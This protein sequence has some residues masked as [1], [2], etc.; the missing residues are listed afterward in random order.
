MNT[1]CMNP[2]YDNEIQQFLEFALERTRLDE[3]EK[4]LCPCIKCLNG[5]RQ[6]VDN[7]WKHFL[8]DGIK[9]NYTTWIWQGELIDMQRGSQNEQADVEMGDRLEN[10]IW[11]LAQKSF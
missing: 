11:D 1:S 8:Y 9:K 4:C 6:V 7:I 5:R 3:D 2:S 10:M